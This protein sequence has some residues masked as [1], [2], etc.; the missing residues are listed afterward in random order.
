M[1]NTIKQKLL[2]E[3]AVEPTENF[4]VK[5]AIRQRIDYLKV[6]LKKFKMKAIVLGI[7][8][9]VDSSTAGK[10]AQM[11]VTELQEEGYP[12]KFIA[13][14]LPAHVQKDEDDA[15]AA[16]KFISPD[17]DLDINIGPMADAAI[18]AVTSSLYHSG[19]KKG[20]VLATEDFTKG[21]IKARMRMISQYAIAGMFGGV[22]LGTDHNSEAVMGFYTKYGD[23]GCDLIVLNGLNKRQVR[24]IAK[25]LGADEAIYSKVATADLEEDKPQLSDE[26]ALGVTYD[27]IDDFLEGKD[28]S[29]KSEDRIVS[30]FEKTI[31]KREMPVSF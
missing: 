20:E 11:A 15:Q 19:V 21:N 9:G 13:I 30:Q 10:L 2:N 14:R 25:E 12:A 28:I 29:A 3:L 1:T 18:D 16:L 26:V 4:D 5:M 8:G 24:L 7:S 6:Y 31:H 17:L 27:E 23:G 22:V